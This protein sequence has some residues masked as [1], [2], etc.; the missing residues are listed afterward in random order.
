MSRVMVNC[1]SVSIQNDIIDTDGL[2]VIG[3]QHFLLLVQWQGLSGSQKV[4]LVLKAFETARL[5]I[6]P[7]AMPEG[8]LVFFWLSWYHFA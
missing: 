2:H 5:R 7:G 8:G 6:H 4:E 3:Y 1:L